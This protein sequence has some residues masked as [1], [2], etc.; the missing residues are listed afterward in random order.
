[1]QEKLEVVEGKVD[2]KGRLAYKHK[3]GGTKSSLLIL[4]IQMFVNQV[5]Q[6]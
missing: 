3:H 4:G 1:M 2:W 6:M 5:F